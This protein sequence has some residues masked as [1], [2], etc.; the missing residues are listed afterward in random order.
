MII[1]AVLV[2]LSSSS[3]SSIACVFFLVA[4]VAAARSNKSR[5]NWKHLISTET[6]TTINSTV[7]K[8]TIKDDPRCK[9]PP[10][11]FRIFFCKTFFFSLF[12]KA[13]QQQPASRSHQAISNYFCSEEENNNGYYCRRTQTDLAPFP[14]FSQSSSLFVDLWSVPFCL[15]DERERA[16]TDKCELPNDRTTITATTVV[17]TRRTTGTT[18]PAATTTATAA[19]ATTTAATATTAAATTTATVTAA[20]ATAAAAAATI[21]APLVSA[22]NHPRRFFCVKS[23]LF[24]LFQV[25]SVAA[26]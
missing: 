22:R 26:L 12:S 5:I 8:A 18:T 21:S 10:Q 6:T 19:A 17:T 23:F 11:K 24:S 20:T 1:P 15:R 9:N 13:V 4:K 16:Q 3:S 2:F 14:I 25:L 7:P